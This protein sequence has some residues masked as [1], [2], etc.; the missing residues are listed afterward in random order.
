MTD[1]SNYRGISFL[2]SEYKINAKNV[3]RRLTNKTTEQTQNFNYLGCDISFKY[4][5]YL[6]QKYP[7][8]NM[9]VVQ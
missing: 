6:K 9:H 1:C 3:T 7:S 8:F 2:N 5:N 4:D